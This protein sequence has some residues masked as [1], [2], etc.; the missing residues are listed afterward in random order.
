MAF[1]KF[2]KSTLNVMDILLLWCHSGQGPLLYFK[3]WCTSNLPQVVSASHDGQMKVWDTN[4]GQLEKSCEWHPDKKSMFRVRACRCVKL[5]DLWAIYIVFASLCSFAKTAEENVYLFT[6]SVPVSIP[7]KEQHN[8]Y[9]C[10][11]SVSNWEVDTT[12]KYKGDILTALAVR[13]V[14]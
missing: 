2:Y 9:V 12:M 8:S 7:K 1:F 13:S 14:C 4:K 10:R 11:W 6:V 3:R 5:L